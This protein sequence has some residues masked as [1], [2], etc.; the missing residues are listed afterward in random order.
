MFSWGSM[1][2]RPSG[3]AF[4]CA[5]FVVV[6]KPATKPYRAEA[7]NEGRRCRDPR[8]QGSF[9]SSQGDA[10][11]SVVIVSDRSE[12]TTAP[13]AFC[14]EQNKA[15]Q[16]AGRLFK[17][18]FFVL[19]KTFCNFPPFFQIHFLPSL[20]H[21]LPAGLWRSWRVSRRPALQV[22]LVVTSGTG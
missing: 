1:V 15:K 11:E 18:F 4:V 19:F 10:A 3:S 8:P 12:L 14:K 21:A 9:P 13:S 5:P 2:F 7:R 16:K 22:R 6:L 20:L 17:R